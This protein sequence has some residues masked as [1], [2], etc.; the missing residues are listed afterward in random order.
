M[1]WFKPEIPPDE[2]PST[3]PVFLKYSLINLVGILGCAL[4]AVGAYFFQ[5][6]G[7]DL[8]K[9]VTVVLLALAGIAV[10]WTACFVIWSAEREAKNAVSINLT[11]AKHKIGELKKQQV[12]NTRPKLTGYLLD[13]IITEWRDYDKAAAIPIYDGELL[14]LIVYLRAFFVN[15][16]EVPTTIHNFSLKITE[17]GK[18]YYSQ[19]AEKPHGEFNHKTGEV[20][21]D[22][23]Q[24]FLIDSKQQA[25][26]GVRIEGDLE[27]HI[28]GITPDDLGKTGFMELFIED[29]FTDLHKINTWL[30]D[31]PLRLS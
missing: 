11:A 15:E 26:R 18:D 24:T 12:A 8:G 22:D 21:F 27:F 5:Y 3:F 19:V 2:Q 4:V 13:F 7:G 6:V 14:G 1:S 16:S 20:E 28:S 25:T 29:S 17:N 10:V 30:I 23:L 9:L 31:R